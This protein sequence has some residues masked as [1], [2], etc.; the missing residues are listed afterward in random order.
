MRVYVAASSAELSRAKEAMRQLRAAGHQVTQDW[1]AEIEAV[2]AANPTGAAK[3]K[4]V[5]WSA[6]CLYGV[7]QADA[8]WLLMPETEGFGAAVELGY[9]I[10]ERRFRMWEDEDGDRKLRIVVSGPSH[11]RSIFTAMADVAYPTDA[12]AF[13]A[14]FSR[15]LNHPGVA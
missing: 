6:S 10:G 12:A 2:G 1:V 8:I 4:R 13:R 9:A 3:S 11:E 7:E 15:Q 14:E 5:K